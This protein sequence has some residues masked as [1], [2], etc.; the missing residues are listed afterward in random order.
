[1]VDISV[2]FDFLPARPDIKVKSINIFINVLISNNDIPEY[3][4]SFSV[5]TSPTVN[6]FLNRG[7]PEYLPD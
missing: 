1:M 5:T 2:F 6:H 7:P 3:Y 4:L